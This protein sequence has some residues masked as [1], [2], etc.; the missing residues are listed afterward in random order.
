[1]LANPVENYTNNATQ[2]AGIR[3]A[4]SLEAGFEYIASPIVITLIII[5]L[6]SVVV[7]LRQAKNIRAEGEVASGGKR[8]PFIFLMAMIGFIIYALIDTASIPNTPLSMRF[9]CFRGVCSL[10]AAP[11]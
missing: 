5:T 9:S 1:M 6:V 3:F 4:R 8:A 2:I 11:G 10:A 7:G